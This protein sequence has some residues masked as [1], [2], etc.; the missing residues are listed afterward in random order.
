MKTI[1]NQLFEASG[2]LIKLLPEVSQP[3]GHYHMADDGGVEAEVGEFLYGLIR[4]LQ[5]E[6]ILETGTYTGVSSMYMA[7]A[8]K[9]NGHGHLTTLEIENT[10]KLRAESLW[11]ACGLDDQVY[12]LLKRSLDFRVDMEYDLLFL[13]SEPNIRWAELERF[14]PHLKPGGFI[15]IHDVPPSMCQNNVNLDH[16]EIKSYPFGDI[17]PLMKELI[18]TG[19]LVKFHMPNPRGSVWFYKPKEEDYQP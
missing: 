7:Q 4:L 6:N 9:D 17:P 16:P 15:G 10:H 18:Q 14:Y 5:P 19:K 1:T 13:D 8:L 2:G 11:N 3:T 12:C